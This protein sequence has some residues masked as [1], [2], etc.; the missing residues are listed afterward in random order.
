MA[1]FT[2]IVPTKDRS[3][4]IT[5]L[6]NSLRNL[7]GL[8]G[9]KPEIIIADNNST[10]GTWEALQRE[11]RNFPMKFRLMRVATP[12]KSAVM[13]EAIRASNSKILAFLDDDVVVDP[14]WLESIHRFLENNHYQVAQGV[15]RIASP[16]ADDPQISELLDRYRTI[17]RVDYGP[18]IQN[19]A[20]LN[21][22]NVVIYR[23]VL[24]RIGYFDQR[25]GPGAAGTSEDVELAKRVIRAGLRIGYIHEAV[26]YH[27]VDRSRLTDDYFKSLHRRQGFS[28]LAIEN[29]GIIRISLEL[30]RSS[31][32]YFIYSIFGRERKRYRS[33]G[34]VYHYLAMLEAKTKIRQL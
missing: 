23:E 21:G 7:R 9:I 34:R 12:G 18:E 4:A 13:N 6:L 20:S 27:R 17:P 33:K 19:L 10:D 32:Q 14:G 11:S 5:K 8:E 31:M 29:R 15:I 25:L 24:D 16:E 22:A 2:I 26:V 28:R 1:K 30:L 3:D